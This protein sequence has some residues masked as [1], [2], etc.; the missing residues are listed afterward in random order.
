MLLSIFFCKIGDVRDNRIVYILLILLYFLLEA[1][2]I[3]LRNSRPP[4]RILCSLCIIVITL[5][6][7]WQ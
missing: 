4:L 6:L 2:K 5:Q 7:Y 1:N 3:S